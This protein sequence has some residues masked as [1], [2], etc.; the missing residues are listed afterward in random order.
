M[1]L[2]GI[3]PL[4]GGSARWPRTVGYAQRKGS[5]HRTGLQRKRRRRP[6]TIFGIAVET[7]LTR[8]D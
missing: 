3:P 5:G 1:M 4:A 6:L 2:A 7:R 8:D